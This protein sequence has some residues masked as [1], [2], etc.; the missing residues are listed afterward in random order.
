MLR[1]I[2]ELRARTEA[3][4]P[5]APATRPP[6]ECGSLA[7]GAAHVRARAPGGVPVFELLPPGEGISAALHP[8]ALSRFLLVALTAVLVWLD[9]RRAHE[10]LLQANFGVSPLWFWTASLL[11]AGCAGRWRSGIPSHLLRHSVA[12]LFA[13]D[14][15]TKSFGSRSVLKAASIWASAGRITALLGRNGCGKSTLLKIGAGLLAADQGTVH[16]AGR[17]YLHPRLSQ[18]AAEGMTWGMSSCIPFA[19]DSVH[20]LKRN[21]SRNYSWVGS[22]CYS[23]QMLFCRVSCPAS[24]IRAFG[25]ANSWP[26]P[27]LASRRSTGCTAPPC[28][29]ASTAVPWFSRCDP[30]LCCGACLAQGSFPVAATGL[31][32]LGAVAAAPAVTYGWLLFRGPAEGDF[33]KYRQADEPPP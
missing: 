14:S 23:R 13:A 9:R 7:P 33:Q 11:S 32:V 20:D 28:S 24:R 21:L 18:L 27:G 26:P 4:L 22:S 5:A 1:L 16:F 30:V 15:I 10:H 3:S 31:W 25:W 8:T 29:G 2:H 6:H 19:V 12:P 17:V